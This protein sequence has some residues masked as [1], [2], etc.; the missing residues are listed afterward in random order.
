MKHINFIILAI[1]LILVSCQSV[2]KE[3]VDTIYFGGDIV[4]MKG[5]SPKY[6]ESLAVKEGKIVFVGNKDE[7][8]K[9]YNGKQV[10]LKGKSMFPGFIDGHCHFYGFGAQAIGANLLASPD[11]NV[12]DIDALVNTLK[13]WATE[14][15]INR[16]GWIYGMGYDDS[17]LKEGRHPTKEDLDRVSTETPIIVTHISAHFAVVNSAGLKALGITADTPDPEGGIIRRMPENNEPNGVLEELAAIPIYMG[18]IFPKDEDQMVYFLD[19]AQE[20]AIKYG[21]TTAEEGRAFGNHEDLMKYAEKKG[22]KIDVLSYLDYSMRNDVKGLTC[23]STEHIHP[24]SGESYKRMESQWTG[25]KYINGYRV[26]GM[27]ISLDGSPQGRTAWAREPYLLPPDGQEQGYKG[28]PAIPEDKDVQ[29]LF[30]VAFKH[31]WQVEIHAN[32]DAAIDQLIRTM[33]PAAEKYGN[34]DRRSVLIHGQFLNKD[35]Y[36]GL[37][38][39]KIIPSM[40]TMHTFYWGDWYKKII[41]PERAQ[42]ICPAKS[43]IDDGF[44]ITI[45]TD[46]PVALPNLMQ[47]VWASVNRVSRSGDVMGPDERITPYQAM[48]AITIWSAWQHFEEDRKGSLEPGKLADLVVLSDNPL[49]IDPM[50]INNIT[51]LETIK[52]GTTVYKSK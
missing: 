35:Q 40:Y 6:V 39:L 45:H 4:T 36:K 23:G 48:Q 31:N 1:A 43:L 5:D 33:K 41:G 2:K 24:V 32:G 44:K 9:K 28:Y 3:M 49:K 25:K 14:E 34:A 15:N 30:E 29:E 22:F 13:K 51:V 52:E 11:G 42:L 27:K 46:A 21:Y 16:T 12:N 10:D 8:I 37:K 26:A 47:I 38:E 50:K 7:A 18:I 20:L 17:V 19:K